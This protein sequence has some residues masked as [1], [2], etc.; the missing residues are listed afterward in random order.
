M[1]DQQQPPQPDV[2]AGPNIPRPD[3]SS[4]TTAQL[5]RELAWLR[6]T[7]QGKI[8]VG[9]LDREWL[10]QELT[11]V[12]AMIEM[13]IS[14]LEALQNKE[15]ASIQLQFSERDVRVEQTARDTKVAVDAALMAAEKAVGKQT[16]SFSLSIDKSERA[17]VK[18]LD[19]QG[20][21]IRTSTEGLKENIND[22]KERIT[23]LES[24][25]VAQVVAKTDA[26]VVHTASQMSSS[27]ML[28]V[29]VAGVSLIGLIV[30]LVVV[31]RG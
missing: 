6:E 12:P 18:L 30:T 24:T 9:E 16:E 29:F 4:L 5:L 31:F 2:Y 26:G 13:Q 11:K 27:F 7:T 14:H 23:R 3:P 8:E 17:T 25:A 22:I 28:A 15:F 1:A 19:Q 10:K 20:E 21:L